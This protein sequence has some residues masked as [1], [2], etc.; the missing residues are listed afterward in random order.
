MDWRKGIFKRDIV[1]VNGIKV[2]ELGVQRNV[3]VTITKLVT[4]TTTNDSVVTLI[5][6]ETEAASVEATSHK[7]STTVIGGSPIIA[8]SQTTTAVPNSFEV[9]G[10]KQNHCHRWFPSPSTL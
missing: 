5:V 3:L 1:V 10:M 4:S 8:R 9:I 6:T 7:N 2:F